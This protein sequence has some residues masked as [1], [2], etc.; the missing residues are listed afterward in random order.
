[1]DQGAKLYCMKY[2]CKAGCSLLFYISILQKQRSVGA[3]F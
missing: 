2:V 1:M 3:D